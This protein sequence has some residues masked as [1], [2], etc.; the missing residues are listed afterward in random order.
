MGGIYSKLFIPN[1]GKQVDLCEKSSL[2]GVKCVEIGIRSIFTSLSPPKTPYLCFRFCPIAVEAVLV[3]ELNMS[4][5][6]LSR[7][8]SHSS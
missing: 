3:V 5:N 7:S 6:I 2:N 8:V 1:S 4:L